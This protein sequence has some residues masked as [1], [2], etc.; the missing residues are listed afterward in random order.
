MSP[1]LA[2]PAAPASAAEVAEVVRA[3]SGP[4][5]AIG[6]GTLAERL[7]LSSDG[8]APLSL[9]RLDGVL[10]HRPDDQV[11]TVGAGLPVA[12]L[13]GVL[14]GAAQEC[15]LDP[16]WPD[17]TVGGAVSAGLN[18]FRRLG[19]GPV[20][21][22]V[23]GIEAVTGD[24]DVIRAGGRTVKNVTGYDLCRLLVASLGRWAVLTE[25]TLRA[26]PR[27]EVGRWYRVGDAGV[28]VRPSAH[29]RTT[30]GDLVLMEGAADELDAWERRTSAAP[31]GA[32]DVEAALAPVRN[33]SARVS[34]DPRRL[35][36][37]TSSLPSDVGWTAEP[38]FGLIHLAAPAD[39]AEG[40]TLAFSPQGERLLAATE[41]DDEALDAAV[42]AAFDARGILDWRR[43]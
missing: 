30:S 12:A 18:G 31:A 36:A 14:A 21:D 6:S 22:L 29:L 43:R 10:E 13:D 42:G 40:R 17:A 11:I 7:G 25:V 3:A 34:V 20:R 16:W 27:P 33:P 35:A 39:V 38:L 41:P 2:E 15:P 28:P 23:L 1:V 9:R 32:A 19:R 5:V 26:Q 37:V 4:I 8:R 24:G